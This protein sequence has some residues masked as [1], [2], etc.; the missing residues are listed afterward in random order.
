MNVLIVDDHPV[1]AEYLRNAAGRAEGRRAHRTPG[2]G[3]GD[4]PYLTGVSRN[5]FAP[6]AS[7]LFR[8]TTIGMYSTRDHASLNDL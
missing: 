1:V 2:P 5:R 6:A 3:D 4:C 7:I 8:S